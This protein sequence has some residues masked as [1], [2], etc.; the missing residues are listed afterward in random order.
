MKWT[1]DKW[2]IKLDGPR[3]QG[4]VR[5]KNKAEQEDFY[6]ERKSLNL[7]GALIGHDQFFL[8]LVSY[9]NCGT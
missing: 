5:T 2:P 1:K 9:C 8:D 4:P 7:H 6:K 3:F